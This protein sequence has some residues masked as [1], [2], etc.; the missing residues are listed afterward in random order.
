M[1]L[2]NVYNLC[3]LTSD[4]LARSNLILIDYDNNCRVMLRISAAYAVVLCLSVW[5]SEN[6][7]TRT[8]NLTFFISVGLLYI[9]AFQFTCNFCYVVSFHTSIFIVFWGF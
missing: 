6:K 3:P 1:K 7:T 2:R 9:V 8:N 4:S 5:V